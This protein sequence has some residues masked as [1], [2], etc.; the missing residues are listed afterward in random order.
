MS[1]NLSSAHCACE[2]QLQ[3]FSVVAVCNASEAPFGD[4]N[5]FRE[6][7]FEAANLL[8]QHLSIALHVLNRHVFLQRYCR[9]LGVV[10]NMLVSPGRSSFRVAFASKK[11]QVARSQKFNVCSSESMTT[12]TVCDCGHTSI[13]IGTPHPHAVTVLREKGVDVT[14][15][16]KHMRD[17]CCC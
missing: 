13:T 10:P 8:A 4:A 15:H 16:N 5:S 1:K 6:H 9:T 7:G 14:S 12:L 11:I 2:D 3:A 17:H